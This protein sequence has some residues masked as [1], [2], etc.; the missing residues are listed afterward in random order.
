M[1]YTVRKIRNEDF[2]PWQVFGPKNTVVWRSQ[3]H[4][5]AISIADIFARRARLLDDL[6]ENGH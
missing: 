5:S 1:K 2:L 6:K 3:L 4:T